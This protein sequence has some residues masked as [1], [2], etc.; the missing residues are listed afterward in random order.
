M[1]DKII[2]KIVEFKDALKISTGGYEFDRGYNLAFHST[3]R[4]LTELLNDIEEKD[5]E[6]EMLRGKLETPKALGKRY[7]NV[8]EITRNR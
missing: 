2:K 1:K 4:F 5:A 3:I 8:T 7:T 6:I